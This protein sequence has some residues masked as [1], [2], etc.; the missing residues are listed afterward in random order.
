MKNVYIVQ[1]NGIAGK[2]SYIEGVYSSRQD[3]EFAGD[4]EQSWRGAK[5]KAEI[6][7]MELD[8]PTSIKK[9]EYHQSCV[10]TFN[11]YKENE[12]E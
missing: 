6:I 3:A 7:E 8:A 10:A 9:L 5:Y 2:H 11:L 12:N 1:M 4:V